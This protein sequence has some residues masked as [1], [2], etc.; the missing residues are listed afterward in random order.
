MGYFA[1][2][3]GGPEE[4]CVLL[5]TKHTSWEMAQL[6]SAFLPKKGGDIFFFPILREPAVAVQSQVRQ[7][8]TLMWSR[9]CL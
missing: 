6:A 5:I 7:A 3:Q 2:L 1:D 4:C 9:Q 8:E